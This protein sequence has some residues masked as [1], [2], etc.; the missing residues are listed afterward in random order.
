MEPSQRSI[1]EFMSPDP[2]A[3]DEALTL[4]D[5]AQR[6]RENDIRHLLVLHNDE[7]IGTVDAHD[8]DLALAVAG[9]GAEHGTMQLA[10]RSPCVCSVELPVAEVAS[11]M[12]HGRYT[13]A[14]IV[15]DDLAVGI[16]TLTDALALIAGER[17]LHGMQKATAPSEN[18]PSRSDLAR[19]RLRVR[20][21][22][23]AHHAAPG[24]NDGKAFGT[25]FNH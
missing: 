4:S 10:V 15:E 16:F 11:R 14:V 21:I 12:Q 24:P 23:G 2:C 20:R 9:R 7:L 19:S 1:R 17:P 8:L 6:M 22:L 18:A 5:A 3:I 25:V 13:C